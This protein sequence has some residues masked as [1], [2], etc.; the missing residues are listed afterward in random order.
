ML[1]V[2]LGPARHLYSRGDLA[3]RIRSWIPLFYPVP[4]TLLD[5][6]SWFV[7]IAGDGLIGCKG[8]VA[9]DQ[10]YSYLSIS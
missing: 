7:N 6:A 8:W 3:D 9:M 1:R 10:R 2:L 4:F 5:L